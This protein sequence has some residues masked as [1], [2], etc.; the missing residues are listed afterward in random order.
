MPR[1]P[2]LNI[3]SQF[4]ESG[5]F[6]EISDSRPGAG[7][8]QDDSKTSCHVMKQGSY[9]R[10]MVLCQK[11]LRCQVEEVPI[12]YLWVNL[13]ISKSNNY[14]G[15]KHIKYAAIHEIVIII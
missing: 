11:K 8:V 9:Q 13:H 10:P 1:L 15:L 14:N 3:I 2:F 4:K 7:N 6:G 5:F 12:G